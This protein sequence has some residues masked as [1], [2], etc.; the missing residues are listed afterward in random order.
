MSLWQQA[1]S[2]PRRRRRSQCPPLRAVSLG[3]EQWSI[4]SAFVDDAVF[5]LH[6]GRKEEAAEESHEIEEGTKISWVEE[7]EAERTVWLSHASIL[8]AAKLSGQKLDKS[9]VT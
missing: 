6:G 9:D 3:S 8:E 2:Y 5:P 4:L 7:D 1:N